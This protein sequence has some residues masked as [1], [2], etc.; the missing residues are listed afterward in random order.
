MLCTGGYPLFVR[1][2]V[3][4]GMRCGIL[5]TSDTTIG[6]CLIQ[7]ICNRFRLLAGTECVNRS[8]ALTIAVFINS[9]VT[10]PALGFEFG[11]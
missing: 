11:F 9:G 10:I 2:L 4:L 7:V 3:K 1:P 5:C 8:V 6:E